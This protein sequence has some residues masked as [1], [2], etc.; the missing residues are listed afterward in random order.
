MQGSPSE[1]SPSAFEARR[2][3][4]FPGEERVLEHGVLDPKIRVR[5]GN[6]GGTCVVGDLVVRV[7]L[8]IWVRRSQPLGSQPPGAPLR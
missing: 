1:V 2:L 7:D 3:G 4:G 8:K 5:L 6:A